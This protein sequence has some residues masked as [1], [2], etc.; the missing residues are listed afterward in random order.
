[1]KPI[2]LSTLCA[3]AGAL[4]P[5]GLI[6]ADASENWSGHCAR[7]HGPDGAGKNKIGIKLKLR[8]FTSAEV[9]KEFTDEQAFDAIK[10]GIKNEK[11]DKFTM[12]A[13][14]EKLSDEEITEMVAF[15]RSMSSSKENSESGVKPDPHEQ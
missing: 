14:G 9:Q 6:A 10:N 3:A 5:A 15:V 1:M 13:F 11:G 8:D 7:C 2:L 4:V 12:N